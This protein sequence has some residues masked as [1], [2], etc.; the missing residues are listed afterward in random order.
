MPVVPYYQ[1]RP[2]CTW[3]KFMSRPARAGAAGRAVGAF[4]ATRPPATT[5]A[6][7]RAPA[8]TNAHATASAG[9]WEAWAANWFTPR[10]QP[11]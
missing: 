1:G 7:R 9:A 11:R 4:P 8:G 5:A 10:R 3:I 2:A 6:Q